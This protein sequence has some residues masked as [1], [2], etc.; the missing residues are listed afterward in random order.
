MRNFYERD[1]VVE[2]IE[3]L[4]FEESFIKNMPFYLRMAVDNFDLDF[5]KVLLKSGADPDI[6]TWAQYATRNHGYLHELIHAYHSQRVTHGEL[7]ESMMKL[8]LGAGADPNRPGDN[9]AAPIQ[10]CRDSS[11]SIKNLLLS[12]GASPEGNIIY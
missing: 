10:I 7:I 3:Y 9:N 8:L 5:L 1:Y 11:E 12:Y 4:I 6:N 2:N